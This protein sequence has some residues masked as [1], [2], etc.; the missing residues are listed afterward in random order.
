MPQR[1][2]VTG[3]NFSGRSRAL[4]DLLRDP[5]FAPPSFFVGPYAEAAL[6][7]LTSSVADEILIYRAREPIAV[8]RP[9]API[10]FAAF[11]RRK[12]QTLSGGEQVMLALHCF[13]QSAYRGV[14]I[15]TALEQLDGS[16]RSSA[17]DYLGRGDENDFNVGIIDNR[18]DAAP[19]QWSHIRREAESAQF[20]ADLAG[21][22]HEARPAAAVPLGIHDLHFRYRQGEDIFRAVNLRLEP[23]I[24]YRLRGRN[25]AGKTTLLKILIGVLRPTSGRLTLNGK[26]Y[27][28]AR[29][30]VIALAAQN[31]DHQ[32]CGATLRED[33]ARRRNAFD[34]H[35]K[36]TLPS[37]AHMERLV[38]LLGFPSLDL[39][40]Y[41]LPLA[42][43][44]RLSWLWPFS[45]TLPWVLLDEPT[46]GQ[47]RATRSALA[48]L[49]NGFAGLGYGVIFITHD[50]DFATE[51]QHREL[52]IAAMTI[53]VP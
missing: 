30:R 21:F 34:T 22:A 1:V 36:T 15:D 20:D 38:R 3:A 37:D 52:A 7:G 19:P 40:L 5:T 50:D 47:D 13:S 11:A 45:G 4:A 9:Y 16:N 31:P 48:H 25:G 6:S 2:L 26:A 28:P 14:G 46:I 33:L 32:W 42:A 53:G 51:V 17:L 18:I 44:K 8:R 29:D 39:R 24:A 10:D 27:R 43:R 35:A 23:G 49:V 12:P 41:E